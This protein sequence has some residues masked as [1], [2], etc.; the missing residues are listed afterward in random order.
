MGTSHNVDQQ[1]EMVLAGA[2]TLKG[3]RVVQEGQQLK[4]DRAICEIEPG[5]PSANNGQCEG[6][7]R[8]D[9]GRRE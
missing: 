3:R 5:L 6:A 4:R 9:S 2:G 1:V 8:P 7:N